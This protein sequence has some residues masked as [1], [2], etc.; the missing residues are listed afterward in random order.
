MEK[1]YV[2][3]STGMLGKAV[4]QE[5]SNFGFEALPFSFA[6]PVSGI[7]I[8]CAGAIPTRRRLGHDMVYSN[9]VFPG[10]IGSHARRYG[11]QK[12]VH[13]STDCVFSGKSK[14]RI[15]HDTEPDPVDLYGKS[16][17]MGEFTLEEMYVPTV[18]V[19]TSFIGLEH[20]LLP[21]FVEQVKVG[22][23]V[24]GY[25]NALWTGSTVWEVA[26]GIVEIAIKD[27]YRFM[28]HLATQR[29]W[30]KWGVLRALNEAL[31]LKASINPVEEPKINRALVPT[32]LIND[33]SDTFVITE[34]TEKFK[35]Q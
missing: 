17:A 10:V 11:I 12:L 21:W 13:I 2:A 27:E 26:R 15:L 4:L 6:E 14:E 7:L 30:S 16:K 35:W 34:L 24:D 18:I 3:G 29:V 32:S 20:G 22:K 1:I 25:K 5:A 28:E 33:L 31:D 9:A 8:N 23:Q 19:R